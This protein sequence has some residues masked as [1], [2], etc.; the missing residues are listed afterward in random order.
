MAKRN[1]HEF[2]FPL[3]GVSDYF[4]YEKQFSKTTPKAFNMRGHDPRT[5]RYRGAQ[6]AGLAKYV[7]DRVSNNRVQ[8]ISHL[9]TGNLI[10][11]AESL[12]TR[13]I[14][15]I[16][17][18]NGTVEKFTSSAF[19]AVTN[20]SSAFDNTVPVIFSALHFGT[21][22]YCDGSVYKTC[23][24]S[25]VS[26]W[27]A[28]AGS[29]PTDSSN[30]ARLIAT[31]RNRIVLSGI[32]TDPHN[33]FM[34]KV[35]D[36]TDWN[37]SPSTTTELDAVA[38][39]NAN[40]SYCP[41]I[42]NCL[43]PYSD[44][45][46]IF[47]GDHSIYQMTGD[48]LAGGQIDLVSDITGMAWGEPYCKS[49]EG[50]IYFFGSRGGVYQMAP[51]SIPERITAKNIGT[52]L[53]SV[54]LSSTI[55]R[56]VWSDSEQGFYV[57]L[58]PLDGSSTTH[59]FYDV[60]EGAWWPDTFGDANMNPTAVHIFDGDAPGDRVVLLGG[61]DGYLRHF[62]TS[63][64]DDDGTAIESEV[65]IGPLRLDQDIAFIVDEMQMK[66][67]ANSDKVDYYIWTGGSAEEA[68]SNGKCRVRGSWYAN[69]NVPS[70]ARTS[71]HAAYLQLKNT[72]ANESWSVEEIMVG[73]SKLGAMRQRSNI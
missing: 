48:P 23:D 40:A 26:S 33:W 5:G 54:D 38:G 6:R 3:K 8:N 25:T 70:R 39:N 10:S 56:M 32:S 15:G 68:F 14:T 41:D 59:Y 71:G 67:G 58:T 19:S 27:T 43:I 46:L 42:I 35:N 31:W 21:L 60:R 53:E 20:G 62:S 55:V 1:F 34:S 11:D 52:R 7:D 17:V 13:N 37:Y 65:W 64:L 29:L 36:P 18:T 49:P 28:S 69:R 57:F 4:S 66:L 50:I 61:L 2:D 12:D 45:L 9:I 47:G 24:G 51:G 16:V 30:E 73:L 44:D 72:C 22:Y 63:A